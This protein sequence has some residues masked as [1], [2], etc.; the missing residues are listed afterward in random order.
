MMMMFLLN[1]MI[2]IR[3]LLP[4]FLIASTLA[5]VSL[6]RLVRILFCSTTSYLYSLLINSNAITHVHI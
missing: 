2:P 5:L 3:A 6:S 4:R 1:I